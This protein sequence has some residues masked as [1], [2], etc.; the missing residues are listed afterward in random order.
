MV[1]FLDELA[2]LAW[3]NVRSNYYSLNCKVKKVKGS[4]KEEISRSDIFIISEIKFSSPSF[5]DIRKDN[6]LRVAE[7]MVKGGAKAL[8]ILTEP[9]IF[10]GS[11]DGFLKVRENF[12][13]PLLMK[14]IIV[15]KVQID[16]AEKI[17]AN[18][19]LLIMS[20][21]DRR[22]IKEDLKD[23][24]KY[25]HNLGLEVILET[26]NLDEFKRALL[27]DADLIG[28]NNRDLR[29]LSVNLERTREILEK[30]NELPKLVVSESGIESKRDIDY[31][32]SFG[33]KAFLIGTAIMKSKDIE[34]KVRELVG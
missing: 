9:K 1:D 5:G 16:C 30:F 27:T 34:A 29:D 4:L 17:G 11:L 6:I 14:D 10:K 3:D 24:I 15:D 21:F 2:K 19:I 20:L 25:A 13:I 18:A 33:V 31:L 28:I 23:M 26:Q 32:R 8:S 22:Y 7:K 12:S